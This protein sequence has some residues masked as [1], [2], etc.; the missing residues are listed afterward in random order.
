MNDTLYQQ[1]LDRLTVEPDHDRFRG[2][3]LDVTELTP[4]QLGRLWPVLMH[5]RRDSGG[6]AGETAR[7]AHMQVEQHRHWPC[8][9][10]SSAREALRTVPQDGFQ[11]A[12]R[13]LSWT[14]PEHRSSLAIEIGGCLDGFTE[15]FVQ[16]LSNPWCIV[17]LTRFAD[18][19]AANKATAELQRR[20]QESS[21]VLREFA[22]AAELSEAALF[23]LGSPD[24][25]SYYRARSEQ[26]GLSEPSRLADD[27]V[28]V[29]FSQAA[30]TSAH[31]AL[32][33]IHDGRTP[34]KADAAFTVDDAHVIARAARIA[35]LRDDEWIRTLVRELIPDCCVA[36]TTANTCPSQSLAVALGHVIEGAPTPESVQA[37]RDAIQVVR[38]A[39][40]KKKIS[41]NL[42]PAERALA[43]RPQVALRLAAEGNLGKSQ[44]PMLAACLE[45]SW[46]QPLR[47]RATDWR[48]QLASLP[49]SRQF[50][51]ELIWTA[52]SQGASTHFMIDQS[53]RCIDCHERPVTID[54]SSTIAL[55]HPLLATSE[56]QDVWRALIRARQIRQPIRQAFREQYAAFA[57]E[58]DANATRMFAG[59]VMSIRPLLGLA[60]R[61]GWFIDYSSLVRRFGDMRVSLTLSGKVYPGLSG[62]VESAEVCFT[63]RSGQR[64]ESVRIRD[65]PAIAFSEMCRAV[66]LLVSVTSFAKESHQVA[67]DWDDRERH[68]RWRHLLALEDLPLGQIAHFRREAL[69]H[70]FVHEIAQD[71]VTIEGNH[72]K[73]GPFAIHLATARVTRSG[74]QVDVDDV[75]VKGNLKAVPWLPYDEQLLERIVALA[76]ALRGSGAKGQA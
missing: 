39:G 62:N 60:G 52:D 58:L 43:Q 20:Y 71:D 5:A 44:V 18:R 17:L 6:L 70:V 22:T 76:I 75:E 9:D 30:L 3:P 49:A 35:L 55:W 69:R 11:S 13:Y 32:R 54:D 38:H 31:R 45:A 4:L 14:L 73:V 19:A 51:R 41:R 26:H 40:V 10:D 65:I 15:S 21:Y 46:C 72:L 24:Y 8:F 1:W 47:F 48:T 56:V 27:P 42:K 2:V 63:Q 16:P 25:L 7:T 57:D 61:E 34:Y 74:E 28:Y 12:A 23:T 68:D 37:L 66:D 64:W 50:V 36:P 59:Q 29:D 33:D 67:A 53:G